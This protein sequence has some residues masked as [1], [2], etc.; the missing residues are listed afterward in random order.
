MLVSGGSAR[1]SLKW[2]AAETSINSAK[3]ATEST[4]LTTG[5]TVNVKAAKIHHQERV[6]EQSIVYKKTGGEQRQTFGMTF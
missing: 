3:Y 2:F 6:I 4:A 5:S 1:D